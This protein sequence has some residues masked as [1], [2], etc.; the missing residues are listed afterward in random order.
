VCA[1]E[2]DGRWIMRVDERATRLF[3]FLTDEDRSGHHGLHQVLLEQ[4]REDGI[5]GGTLW[6]GI[7]GF[8]RSGIVR[9]NRFPDSTLGLPLILEFIDSEEKIA[10]FLPVLAELAPASLVTRETVQMSRAVPT[11]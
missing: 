6:R 3:V 2:L 9:S 11:V 1:D 4:A 8:G 7:E 10:S 5:A